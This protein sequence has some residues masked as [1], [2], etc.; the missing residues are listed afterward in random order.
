MRDVVLL[1]VKILL[2][3]VQPFPVPP[4]DEVGEFDVK[5]INVRTDTDNNATYIISDVVGAIAADAENMFPQGPIWMGPEETLTE[6]D[7]DRYVEDRIGGQ[8][9]QL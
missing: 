2:A 6:G 7:K 5:I 3:D 4:L 1:G 9:M 8:L